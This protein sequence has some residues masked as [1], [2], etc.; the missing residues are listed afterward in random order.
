VV[1]L[2]FPEAESTRLFRQAEKIQASNLKN[3]RNRPGLIFDNLTD[4]III[5][6]LQQQ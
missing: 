6:D 5:T 1:E 3:A 4:A 2:E